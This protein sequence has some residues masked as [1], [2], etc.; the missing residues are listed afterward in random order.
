MA[1][2]TRPAEPRLAPL[3]PAALDEETRKYV[4][5]GALNI[6]R[7][8]ARHP[9]L[10]KR[11]LVFG[12]HVLSKNTLPDRERELVI[13]RTGWRCGAEY[14]FGQHTVIGRDVGITDTEIA[15]LCGPLDAHPWSAGE[16][17]LLDAV[18]ELHE[19]RCIGDA[20]WAMLTERFDDQQLVDLVFTVGQYT[21]VSM[22]LNTF[23]VELDEGIP[24]WPS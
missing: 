3:D 18:D 23:G 5:D 11:W 17:V 22:A 8:L 9:K 14:E 15:A 1:D 20:T 2:P 4:P 7:T 6:F 24:G 16:R 10:L 12:A 13:L 21:L 19:H